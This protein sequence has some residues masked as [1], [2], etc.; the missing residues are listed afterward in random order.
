MGPAVFPL[1]LAALAAEFAPQVETAGEGAV[2]FS[3][4]GLERLFGSP[5]Q[6]AAEIS[7]RGAARG[8]VHAALAIA[9]NP[10]TALLAA[11]NLPGVTVIPPGKEAQ[12]LGGLPVTALPATPEFLETMARWG[13]ATLAELASL[14]PDGLVERLGEE[15]GRMRRLALGQINRPLQAAPARQDYVA[16]LDLD[17]PLALREQLLFV[18]SPLLQDLTRRLR[19]Q[20]L[21]AC[22]ITLTLK[23]E[24]GANYS[25]TL[26]FPLPVNEAAA[27][28]KQAQLALE[29][30]PPGAAVVA[31]EVRLD[32]AKPRVWQ[33][34]L[35][36]P[37][38][39][40]PARLHTVLARLH[41]L[42]GPGQAGS[43][44]V[45]NTHRRDAHIIRQYSLEAEAASSAADGPATECEDLPLRLSCRL[46]R[47]PLAAAVKLTQDRPAWVAARGVEGAVVAAAGPWRASGEWWAPAR[48][49]REEWDVGLDD[50]ALYRICRQPEARWFVDGVYD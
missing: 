20:A 23:L 41:A 44:A 26:E 3:I 14:P 10:D 40:A 27:L 18:I 5:C 31:L 25:R 37:A 1:D 46:F 22:R 21:A 8:L 47:P 33:G 9:A 35:F 42:V 30:H 34:G 48:W 6:L 7:R 39:P 17:E 12:V 11:M 2:I 49:E 15:G 24:G 36:R 19:R 38:A 16:R 13:I 32:P 45:L 29:A 43:P 50:G 28:L 4:D